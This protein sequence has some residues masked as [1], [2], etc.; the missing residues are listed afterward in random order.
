[1]L[2]GRTKGKSPLGRPR[3]KGDD[4]MKMDFQEVGGDLGLDLSG[5]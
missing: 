3:Q 2:F 5:P 1:M 4:N